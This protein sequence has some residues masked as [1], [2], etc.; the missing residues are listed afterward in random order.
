MKR[1]LPAVKV[2]WI[3]LVLTKW[4][5]QN[6]FQER[7]LN[8]SRHFEFNFRLPTPIANISWDNKVLTSD[9]ARQQVAKCFWNFVFAFVYIARIYILFRITNKK[10]EFTI[11]TTKHLLLASYT[12]WKVC[13]LATNSDHK[14]L[15]EQQIRT[16]FIIFWSQIWGHHIMA[17]I[18]P[19]YMEDLFPFHNWWNWLTQSYKTFFPHDAGFSYLLSKATGS[20]YMQ[21]CRNHTVTLSLNLHS[22]YVTTK[23]VCALRM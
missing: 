11:L 9:P 13:F 3:N 8:C 21:L 18:F 15:A 16:F 4:T 7:R 10:S 19:I 23:Y 12:T 6:I 22:E 17:I 20:K 1:L 2:F 14:K 5:E